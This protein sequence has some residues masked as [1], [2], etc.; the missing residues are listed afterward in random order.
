MNFEVQPGRAFPLLITLFAKAQVLRIS[1]IPYTDKTTVCGYIRGYIPLD[2]LS[3]SIHTIECNFDGDYYHFIRYVSDESTKLVELLDL[4]KLLPELRRLVLSGDIQLRKFLLVRGASDLR[5]DFSLAFTAEY[6]VL[7]SASFLDRLPSCLE[8]LHICPTDSSRGEIISPP[9]Q[10]ISLKITDMECHQ[11]TSLPPLLESLS[12]SSFSLMGGETIEFGSPFPAS[13]RVL[14]VPFDRTIF[15]RLPHGLTSLT[16]EGED[17]EGC[18]LA[19]FKHLSQLMQLQVL[20]LPLWDGERL[21]WEL[22]KE[23]PPSVTEFKMLSSA[24]PIPFSALA[25]APLPPGLQSLEIADDYEGSEFALPGHWQPPSTLK[26]LAWYSQT[27]SARIAGPFPFLTHLSVLYLPLTASATLSIPTL[28]RLEVTNWEVGSEVLK[29][30]SFELEHLEIHRGIPWETIASLDLAWPSLASLKVLHINTALSK[31]EKVSEGRLWPL[32]LKRSSLLYFSLVGT[33]D[34][35]FYISPKLLFEL[36]P[37][38]TFLQLEPLGK[39]EISH[40]EKLPPRLYSLF[41]Y[42]SVKTELS[43]ADFK[44]ILP[45]TLQE[46]HIISCYRYDKHVFL[47]T[48]RARWCVPHPALP[49]PR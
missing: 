8:T 27:E 34:F 13:L 30:A 9:S 29:D 45:K 38:L 14:S 31:D 22:M 36:P 46:T 5:D 18:D 35:P 20:R 43:G 15:H 33:A 37:K 47:S 49:P 2:L 12:Y 6:P 42:G 10:L 48:E 19:I 41:L 44:S 25:L 24:S 4:K 17:I 11:I 23:F 32:N 16:M 26:R 3:K 28:K 40:L 1:F 7:S 39:M 21:R